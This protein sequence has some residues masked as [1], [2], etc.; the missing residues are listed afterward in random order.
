MNKLDNDQF[1]LVLF[2]VIYEDKRNW[3]KRVAT[4]G[5][6]QKINNKDFHKLLQLYLALWELKDTEY[7]SKLVSHYA[8]TFLIIPKTKTQK[9]GS[10][11]PD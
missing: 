5:Q 1:V 3:N 7:K 2:R 10:C 6:A 4:L 11:E 9:K 8:I